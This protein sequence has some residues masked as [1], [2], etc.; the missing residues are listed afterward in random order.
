MNRLIAILMLS[1][2]VDGFA[3]VE[4]KSEEVEK[5]FEPKY[6]QGDRGNRAIQFVARIMAGRARI[7]WDSVLRQV[8]IFGSADHVAHAEELL[9]K[10]DVPEVR[11]PARTFEF[12]IYLVGAY[13]DAAR[14]RGGPMPADLDSVV[15]EMRGAFAYKGFSLLDAI[16]VTARTSSRVT[17]YEGILP[18]TAVGTSVKHFYRV[19]MEDPF[20]LDDGK[21]VM[22]PAFR[23][24]VDIP[25]PA[26]GA[27]AGE[28]GIQSD[29]A[30][31][32]GQKVVLGKIRLDDG[33]NAVFL[34]ITVK[35]L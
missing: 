21:T 13:A 4:K 22:T 19:F 12:T 23:F 7:E 5:S 31:R 18:V 15:K 16:P 8:V 27:K 30:V 3:Q 9:R 29:L 14:M 33:E 28:T 1:L 11:K 34:V 17:E 2:A 10:F 25:N 35:I 20:L 26:T 32:E 6:L 24:R